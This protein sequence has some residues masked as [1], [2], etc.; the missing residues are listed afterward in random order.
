MESGKML[1]RFELDDFIKAALKEDIA[2]GDI[3]TDS[4][5]DPSSVSTAAYIAKDDGIVA[6][7]FVSE[8]V[9]KILDEGIEFVCKVNDGDKI[10]KGDIIA[11]IKGNTSALLKAERTSLNYL[12]HLSG[13]STKTNMF[14]EKLKGLKTKVVDTRKTTPG[15]RALEKYA[16]KMGGG[17]NHRFCLSDG[18]LIKDNHIKAAGGVK[19]AIEKV[20]ANIPHTIKIEVETENIEQVKE[21]LDAKADIIM[22]DNMNLDEMKNAVDLID[23]RATVEASGNVNLESI[24][25]IAE[26]GVDIISVG[27]LTHTVKAFDISMRFV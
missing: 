4:L 16:V 20:R 5:I 2:L 22:L 24:R 17:S 26:T 15:L 21:A 18:V 23:G 14:A 12:Q 7:L 11:E 9:F 27:E 6:G 13:I 8:R 25:K 19:A 3:T 1:N 10:K